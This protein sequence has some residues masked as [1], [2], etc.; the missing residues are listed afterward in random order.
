MAAQDLQKTHRNARDGHLRTESVSPGLDLA[1]LIPSFERS[2]R[3]DGRSKRTVSDYVKAAHQLDDF[4]VEKGMPT[5]PTA[6]TRDHIESFIVSEL[7]RVKASTAASAYRRIQQF[8]RWLTEEGET[9]IN[10]MDRMSPPTVVES[11]V[12]VLTDDEV[13]ALIAQVKGTTFVARRDNAI[14]RVMLDTGVR[15]AEVAGMELDDLSWDP[16]EIRVRG[17]GP[18]GEKPRDVPFGARTS[19]ALDRYLRLRARHRLARLPSLWLGGKG[20]LTGSG[21]AQML[22]R[23][24][25]DAGIAHIHPH[26][27][28]HTMSHRW[29][30]SGGKEGDLMRLNGWSSREMVDRYARSVADQRARKA[31]RKLGLGDAY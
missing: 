24:A 15:R 22:E 13:K 19:Q 10:P 5:D 28:R 12:P 11:P 6:L 2:L 1:A 17:K 18:G 27:L 29:L 3:A 31:H 14:I 4:L 26:R 21:I 23:R 25:T 7:D 20:Q 9:A 16:E 30:D 8:F